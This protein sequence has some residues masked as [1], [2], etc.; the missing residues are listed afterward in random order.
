MLSKKTFSI[1]LA[2]A[3]AAVLV[4]GGVL[5]FKD[6][7]PPTLIL[8]P[9]GGF[10]GMQT[11]FTARAEDPS[12]LRSL[13]AIL[14]RDGQ[15]TIL[16]VATP[17]RATSAEVT[18][19]L[20]Q[21]KGL[22]DGPLHIEI[23]AVDASMYRMNRGNAA[24]AEH[25]L[26]LDRKK[27]RIDVASAQHNLNRGGCGAIAYT[28]NEETA[29]TGVRVG[30]RFFPGHKL[31]SGSYACLFACP[32]DMAAA[33]FRPTIEAE[34]RAGN[35]RVQTFAFHI[36][37]REF[38]HDTLNLPDSFLEAKMPQFEDEYPNEANLLAVYLR[39]NRETRARDRAEIKA[40]GA[41]TASEPLWSGTFLRLPNAANRAG[42]ADHRTY[43]YKGEAVDEQ[44]HLGIDLASVQNAEVPA[45]NAGRVVRTG[46]NGIYGENVVIDHGLG[47][48]TLYAHL[49]QI[50]VEVGDEVARGQIIGRTGATGLAG[51][52]HLHYGVYVNGLAVNPL[53]WWDAH[54]IKNNVKD[55]LGM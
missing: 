22:A 47:L 7:V 29:E 33:D 1:L 50:G 54:W 55:R 5:Y 31:P 17:M 16:A 51:G 35:R 26:T 9:D 15:R 10:V 44:T 2:V 37:D 13:S 8:N 34:D 28:V 11:T 52:D 6:T 38:K 12:G 36:N 19:T 3:L 46:F 18:F 39:V 41:D 53:E 40:L 21:A 43:R 4:A 32:W 27:P 45:A 24:H 42:F 20:E 49:S 14:V 25:I 30:E 48:M 23:D